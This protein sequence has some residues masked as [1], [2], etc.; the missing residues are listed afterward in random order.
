MRPEDWA[1]F[2]QSLHGALHEPVGTI[3]ECVSA[4]FEDLS[5][6]VIWDKRHG[7]VYMLPHIPCQW[8]NAGYGG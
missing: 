6:I 7:P 3:Q 2:R 4:I 8:T 1:C 5:C